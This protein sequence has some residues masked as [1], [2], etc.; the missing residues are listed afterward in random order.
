MTEDQKLEA[1][2]KRQAEEEDFKWVMNDSRG[3]RVMRRILEQAGI[4]QLSFAAES[5]HVTAFNEGR[6]NVGLF[7]NDEILAICPEKWVET[8]K[9]K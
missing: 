7:V 5:T 8:M 6:R 9:G 1:R 2:K 4:Y 3:Q